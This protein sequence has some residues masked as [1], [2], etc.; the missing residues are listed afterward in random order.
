MPG[1]AAAK[2]RWVGC[3]RVPGEARRSLRAIATIL[4]ALFALTAARRAL[5]PDGGAA[6]PPGA[7]ADL[8]PFSR[9][10]NRC[11]SRRQDEARRL[12]S[13]SHRFSLL[14]A[15]TGLHLPARRARH[16]SRMQF[17]RQPSFNFCGQRHKRLS[18][19][20]R[21]RAYHPALAIALWPPRGDLGA[22]S[23]RRRSG[24][25]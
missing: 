17:E 22:G 14:L 19:A 15:R 11:G 16:Q 12:L 13:S 9:P 3:Y 6:T 5:G 18:N 24:S 2:V 23:A 4:S 1:G 10:T 21:L 25:T 7:P 20:L 8:P